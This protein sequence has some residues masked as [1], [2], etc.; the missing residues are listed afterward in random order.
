MDSK[1]IFLIF[2]LVFLVINMIY[3]CNHSKEKFSDKKY[4]SQNLIDMFNSL[5][6]AEKRCEELEERRNLKDEKE[7][8]KINEATF[9]ELEELDKKIIE[10]KEIL[11]DLTLDK[12]R[13]DSISNKCRSNKQ[14]QLN[15]N[16]DLIKKLDK[17]GL[18]K[19]NKIDLDLNIS[20]SLNFNLG[21]QLNKYS[22]DSSSS[23]KCS[24]KNSKYYTNIDKN[25]ISEKCYNCDV[26]KLKQNYP[27]LNKDFGR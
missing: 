27:Y 14:I 26:S 24:V 9:N 6:V 11:K 20:D 22:G 18:A 4:T 15:R 23:P 7:K 25:K 2:L 17:N 12:K 16:Y 5:E 10:L 1:S 3:L 21:K 8:I 13:K 19:D